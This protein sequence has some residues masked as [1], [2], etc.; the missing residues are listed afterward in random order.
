[1]KRRIY[2]VLTA[3]L[4][5]TPILNSFSANA[6]LETV[7]NEEL[8]YGYVSEVLPN[9]L[10][11]SNIEYN[12]V[13][14][15]TAH[16][17]VNVTTDENVGNAYLVFSDND[18][19]GTLQIQTIDSEFYSSFTTDECG[20]LQDAYNNGDAI[21]L[22]YDDD[23]LCAT[24]LEKVSSNKVINSA[25]A[26]QVDTDAIEFS[27]I[28]EASKLNSTA[29]RTA[30]TTVYSY[31]LGVTPVANATINGNGICWVSSLTAKYNYLNDTDFTGPEMY[32]LLDE[33]FY[34]EF[35][36]H[37]IGYWRWINKA[38]EFL[39]VG[40]T[41]VSPMDYVDVYAEVNSNNPIYCRIART[42]GG[43]AVLLCGITLYSD[44]TGIY[45]FADPNSTSLVSISVSAEVMTDGTELV[46][47][48]GYTYTWDY[49]LI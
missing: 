20:I 29:T 48:R 1:M 25:T 3:M 11:S 17:V 44:G 2:A 14:I 39:E 42:G 12:N 32:E 7:T 49:S 36:E 24:S 30:K 23:V 18:Y 34:D 22:Y 19:I 37:P 15:S 26:S 16:T 41:K 27:T 28:K 5:V 8:E 46:Y 40:N 21:A 38:A 10:Q 43:H 33:E 35:N 31:T 9:Y 47:T 13:W 4:M 6:S 45:H